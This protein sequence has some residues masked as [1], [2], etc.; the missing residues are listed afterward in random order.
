MRNWVM[1]LTLV[2]GSMVAC[3]GYAASIPQPMQAE[4]VSVQGVVTSKSVTRWLKQIDSISANWGDVRGKT[5]SLIIN[6]PGGSVEAGLVLLSRLSDLQAR[7]MNLRCY[8]TT[9]AASMAFQLYTQCNERYA[10][11]NSFL[12]W[13][14]V[15]VFV[16]FGVI[17][18]PT[19][20]NLA[21]DLLRYDRLIM[22]QLEVAFDVRG[23]RSSVDADF[24][25]HHF[26]RETLWAAAELELEVPEFLVTAD[27][28]PGIYTIVDALEKASPQK[29]D[30]PFD[31]LRMGEIV[32]IR[33]AEFAR[34]SQ[35]Q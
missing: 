12:L 13:H 14:R 18:G 3:T 30:N 35:Q 2:M 16:M 15:R 9:V 27:A 29:S 11:T 7:G 24:V 28:I 31:D 6:S 33:D 23:T 19:A 25:Q 26:D 34:Y 10:L 8:V 21:E 17:T 20:E 4:S 1:S 32:Y 22:R 5:L